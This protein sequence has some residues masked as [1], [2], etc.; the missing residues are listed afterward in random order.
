MS[1]NQKN[2]VDS[3]LFNILL[4]RLSHQLLEDFGDFS[5]CVI[6]GLQPRGTILMESLVKIIEKE[7]KHSILSG[8][9]DISFFRD[10]FR[11]GDDLIKTYPTEINF[12]LEGKTVILIDDVLYTGRS[13]NAGLT[14]LNNYGRADRVVLLCLVDRRF[15]RQLPIKANYTGLVVDTVDESYIKV[16]WE[17]ID[18]NNSIVL[19][20][21]EI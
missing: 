7:T 13:V 2:L 10:D 14:A 3:G 6:I 4:H 8:K 11:R 21:K 5:D 20:S 1:G 19:K 17:P 9:L 15:D 16:N 12:S 18:G